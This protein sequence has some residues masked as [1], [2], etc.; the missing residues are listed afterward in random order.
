MQDSTAVS[1]WD[2][3]KSAEIKSVETGSLVETVDWDYTGQFLAA[4][5]PSGITVS[6]YSKAA[7]E[8]TQPFKAASP[9]KSVA[10]GLAARSLV[11]ASE[12]GVV[13]VLA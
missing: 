1:I 6:Q 5:G 12:E 11:A 10:W 9:A 4:A 7:K 2:I 8:W 3:R 13:T